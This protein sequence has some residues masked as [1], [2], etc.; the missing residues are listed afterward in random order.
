MGANGAGEAWDSGDPAATDGRKGNG[1]GKALVRVCR[2]GDEAALVA[3]D[4]FLWRTE[5]MDEC[6][7]IKLGSGWVG[8]SRALGATATST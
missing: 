3:V 1:S 5:R 7:L 2:I 4:D 6:V 8:T